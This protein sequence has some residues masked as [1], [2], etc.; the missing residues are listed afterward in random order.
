M[1]NNSVV[2]AST[3][4][5]LADMLSV[6]LIDI[7]FRVF[8]V[9]NDTDLF[10]KINN[11]YPRYIFIENCYHN[12]VT[13]E[14][15]HKIKRTNQNLHIIIWTAVEITPFSI[16]RFINA[17]DESIFSLREKSEVVNKILFNFMLGEPYCPIDASM[18]SNSGTADPIFNVPLTK[19]ERQVINFLHLTDSQI[20]NELYISINTVH[21]HKK[22]IFRKTGFKKRIEVINWARDMMIN[23][24]EK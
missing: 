19:K 22:N 23:K 20:A 1:T 15:M 16:A 4:G 11:Y 24:S 10:I 18:V 2:I 8:S 21:F 6:K 7:H 14:Y 5:C 12:N 9:S 3:G 17:G 13:D